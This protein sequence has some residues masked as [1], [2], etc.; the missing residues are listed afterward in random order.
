MFQ[1]CSEQV[2]SRLTVWFV[3]DRP[4]MKVQKA[5]SAA[6]FCVLQSVSVT[7]WT[8]LAWVA[9]VSRTSRASL[10][11][12]FIGKELPVW[13]CLEQLQF[14][15]EKKKNFFYCMNIDET[16]TR[17][18][19]IEIFARC[20]RFQDSWRL[21][22]VSPFSRNCRDAWRCCRGQS[23][24]TQ[25]LDSRCEPP[26]KKA[27]TLLFDTFALLT[28]CGIATPV[29]WTNYAACYVEILHPYPHPHPHLTEQVS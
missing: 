1:L 2:F 22:F 28:F 19:Q 7:S 8:K 27:V 10:F 17:S 4:L 11:L 24:A 23:S 21:R 26:T 25:L 14:E 15:E 6:S 12:L 9:E 20:L 5:G 3:K 29:D 18:L 13:L 16:T